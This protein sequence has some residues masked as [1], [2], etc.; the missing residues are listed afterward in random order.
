MKNPEKEKMFTSDQEVE[1]EKVFTKEILQN[2]E[3]GKKMMDQTT[4][5]DDVTKQG[6]I[7]MIEN[8]D[9][10]DDV[11]NR[12]ELV[13]LLEKFISKRKIN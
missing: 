8:S 12:I 3:S 4:V 13:S 2:E 5:T 7:E 6:I 10:L 11:L 1:D 9:I